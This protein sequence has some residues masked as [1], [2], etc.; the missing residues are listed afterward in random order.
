M[1]PAHEEGRNICHVSSDRMLEDYSSGS[2]RFVGEDP[3]QESIMDLKEI[4]GKS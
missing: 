3:E 1:L 2:L 4:E